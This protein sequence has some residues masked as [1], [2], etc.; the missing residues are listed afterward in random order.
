[1]RVHLGMNKKNKIAFITGLTGQDG[2]YLAEF[3]LEKNYIVHGLK[4]RS[5]VINTDRIDHIY[6]SIQKNNKRFYIHYGDVTDSININ[7]LIKKIKPDEVYNLA[8]QSHVLVSFEAPEYTANVNA[9]GVLR[10]LEAIKSNGLIKKTRFYQAS[11]SELY[12]GT[13]EIPQNEN[14]E[15]YPKSPYG[16]AKLFGHWI[17]VNYREAYGMF[18]CNGILFNHESERRGE[19]FITRK[20]TIGLSEIYHGLEKKLYVG[21]LD[22]IRDWGHAKDYVEMQWLMLQQ[23][24]PNDYV[25]SSG[26]ECT[27]RNFIE[28]AAESIGFRIKWA[29]KGLN[30]Y[31][32]ISKISKETSNI[33]I[34]DKIIHIDKRYFRPTEVNRLCGDSKKARKDLKWEPKINLKNLIREMAQSDLKKSEEKLFLKNYRSKEK[35]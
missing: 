17:T 25:I 4:R 3:L 20:V 14:S 24:K 8:A 31:G 2:S 5:S 22:A 18:A 26:I 29:G 21:N 33:K 1:M 11:T 15:F 10:I 28:L 27:V 7:N 23:K 6:E 9:M 16:V 13:R 12:G 19:T 35:K 30:E 32:Y 34:G